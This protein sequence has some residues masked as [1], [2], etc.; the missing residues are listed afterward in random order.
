MS[1]ESLNS[2][3]LSER[4][5]QDFRFQTFLYGA[6]AS[7]WAHLKSQRRKSLNFTFAFFYSLS[8]YLIIISF[9]IKLANIYLPHSVEEDH[10][11]SI[12]ATPRTQTLT[13]NLS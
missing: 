6:T 5:G 12:S 2:L 4:K 11:S 8:S 1:V 10:P 7:T 3:S 9:G 13:S